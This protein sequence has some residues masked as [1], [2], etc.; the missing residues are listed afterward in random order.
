[1]NGQRVAVKSDS[2]ISLETILKSGVRQSPD[3]SA[4]AALGTNQLAVLVWHYH[5]DDIS[6]PDATVTLNVNNLPLKEG[7]ARLE[8]FRVDEEHSN[9]F[10]EWRRMGCP[11]SLTEAQCQRLEAAGKLA[12]PEVKPSVEIKS[13][14][15]KIEFTLPRQGVSLLVLS[16]R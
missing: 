3:V 16:W 14:S 5:D 11:S 4:L 13:G 9:A 12:A 2:A 10:T 7:S 15:A 1:M 8:Q 6:G